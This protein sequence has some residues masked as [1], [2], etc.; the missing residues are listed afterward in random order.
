MGRKAL[1]E[2]DLE[3]ALSDFDAA[4]RLEPNYADAYTGRGI[5][6]LRRGDYGIAFKE[7]DRALKLAPGSAEAYS[8]RGYAAAKTGIDFSSAYADTRKAVML[9]PRSAVFRSRYAYALACLGM[10][11]DAE[12][13]A[14]RALE[15]D[16]GDAEVWFNY[17]GILALKGERDSALAKFKKAFLLAPRFEEVAKKDRDFRSCDVP[18]VE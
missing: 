16:D 10:F 9:E 5:V 1:M 12:R 14:E 2:G 18:V 11:R 15:L 8:G 6:H 7:F 4:V 13:E 3:G 17:G